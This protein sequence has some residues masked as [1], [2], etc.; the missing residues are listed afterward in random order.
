[1]LKNVTSVAWCSRKKSSPL[2]VPYASNVDLDCLD[3]RLG[4]KV[5]WI[6]PIEDL[7]EVQISPL[8]H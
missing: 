3:P 5:E 8:A 2:L 4:V 7:N 1:M 6:M